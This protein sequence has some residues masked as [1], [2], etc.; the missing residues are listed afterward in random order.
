MQVQFALQL[1]RD[2]MLGSG[3]SFKDCDLCPEM[4]WI[5][6]GRM[7]QRP[8]VN[9]LIKWLNQVS[10]EY[11]LAV[12]K[13]EVTYDQWDACAADGECRSNVPEGV[14][15][16]FLSDTRWG[17][18]RMPVISISRKD[19][20]TYFGWLKKKTG[21]AYRLLARTEFVYAARAGRNTAYPWG[22]DVGTAQ[23]NCSN[24][25]S[26]WDRRQTAP[27]G[28]FKPNAW[29]LHDMVGNAAEMVADCG[30]PSFDKAPTNGA[31]VN[32][33][34]HKSPGFNQTT[35]VVLGGDWLSPLQGGI[36][37]SESP[38]GVFFQGGF[39]VARTG[40]PNND[41]LFDAESTR[42]NAE[43]S[44]QL[45]VLVQH[46]RGLELEVVIV[47]GM[48]VSNGN[49]R[50]DRDAANA[51]ASA[52]RDYLAQRGVDAKR[53]YV[54]GRVRPAENGT[55]FPARVVQLETFGRMKNR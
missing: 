34:C 29:G 51:M 42:L 45:D 53:I 6:P 14:T 23:A 19:M 9:D 27:V 46:I 7:S 16:G 25:G 54:E 21:H 55:I 17:R 2:G 41:I 13:F 8:P 15:K 1:E 18:G 3:K 10:F 4:V 5:P 40:Q 49:V 22:D 12:G 52:V 39:R 47:V 38:E 24:C 28:S 20:E 43:G 44:A 30:S 48:V 11:P 36:P 33:G 26:D 35:N 31:P 32:T 37:T 50:S